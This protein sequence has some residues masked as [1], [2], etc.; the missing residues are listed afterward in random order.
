MLPIFKSLA[1]EYPESKVKL[2]KVDTDVHEEAVD[3]FNIQ[4]VPLFGVFINGQMVASHSGAI[5]RDK[6]KEFI[7]KNANIVV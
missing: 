1:E 5:T 2:V 7:D 3:Q 4:G 6:L